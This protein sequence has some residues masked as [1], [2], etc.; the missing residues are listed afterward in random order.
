M[1]FPDGFPREPGEGCGSITN[2]P[3]DYAR[4]ERFQRRKLGAK[5]AF[6]RSS[7]CLLVDISL[8]QYYAVHREIP[9]THSPMVD[10][11]VLIL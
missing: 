9:E 7:T 11:S 4:L 2:P 8:N 1:N 6:W 3:D 5:I 10:Q